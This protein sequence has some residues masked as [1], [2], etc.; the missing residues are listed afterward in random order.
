[1]DNLPRRLRGPTGGDPASYADYRSE[2]NSEEWIDN[3]WK[4]EEDNTCEDQSR[5]CSNHRP[6]GNRPGNSSAL[7]RTLG[8]GLLGFG[9]LA[10][11]SGFRKPGPEAKVRI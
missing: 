2:L 4:R 6:A 5:L 11:F 7:Q 1:M 9:S 3:Q 8:P 10:L